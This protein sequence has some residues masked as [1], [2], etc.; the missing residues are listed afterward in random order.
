[1]WGWQRVLERIEFLGTCGEAEAPVWM[2]K[3][4]F[5]LWSQAAKI[6]CGY[7]NQNWEDS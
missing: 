7:K 4:S 1:M 3:I 2:H 5:P 6:I